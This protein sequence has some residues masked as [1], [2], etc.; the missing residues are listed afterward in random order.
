MN[1]LTPLLALAALLA[2][3]S[4]AFEPEPAASADQSPFVPGPEHEL[5]R[6][7]VG[8]WD[9]VLIARDPSGAEQRTTG[10]RTTVEHAGFH[11]V[12][13][14]QG[15]FLGVPLIGHGM[16]GYC[17]VRAQYFTFWT[18]SMTSSPLT[19]F[20]SYDAA[21]RTLALSGEC[22]GPSGRLEPCRTVTRLV[23]ADHVSWTLLGAGPDGK[24]VERL[25]IQYTRRPAGG[26]H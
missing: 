11:T 8:T 15:T 5:L 9:A 4:G 1:T 26:G 20:G 18:D 22:F 13:S 3:G 25:T 23:D 12:D 6:G 17:T 2:P 7:L 19:L 10:T 24:E 16:N 21:T 14:F